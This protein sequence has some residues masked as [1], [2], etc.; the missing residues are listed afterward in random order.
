ML[1]ASSQITL[2][3]VL[4]ERASPLSKL[5]NGR[6]MVLGSGNGIGRAVYRLVNLRLTS[7]PYH[8]GKALMSGL[9]KIQKE[10]KKRCELCGKIEETR[11]YG[12]NGARVCFDCGMKN[13]PAA[14]RRA[15]KYLFGEDHH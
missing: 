5:D 9:G 11:P 8:K 10:S 3:K 7:Y 13:E 6:L 4:Y 2:L 12:P 14:Q 1:R 15:S